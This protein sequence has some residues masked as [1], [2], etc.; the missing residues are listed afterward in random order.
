MKTGVEEMILQNYHQNLKALHINCQKP[1][2]YYIPYSSSITA[3]SGRRES[4]DRLNL[5]SG[6]WYFNYY[7]SSH[8]IPE[9]ILTKN[10]TAADVKLPVPSNWQLHGYDAPQYTN[11]DFPVPYDPPFVPNENPAGVYSREFTIDEKFEAHRHLINF[12][13]VDSCFYLYING[14]FVAYSQVSHST[15]EID[16][17]D[18]VNVGTNRITVI[19]L[20]WC[21]GTYL[22]DQDKFRLS[23]IFRDVYVLARPKGHIEDYFVRTKVSDDFRT[24]EIKIDIKAPS[25]QGVN[26][27]LIDPE[28][29][30]ISRAVTDIVGTAIFEVENPLLWSAET[31]HLYSLI[32]ECCGEFICEKVGIK[33]FKVDN[34]VI[35]LNGRAIKLRGTNRHDSHPDVGYAVTEQQMLKDLMLMKQ[36][37]INAIRSAHYP[38]DP[39]FVQMCDEYGFYL[40]DEADLECHGVVSIDGG[41]KGAQYHLIAEDPEFKEAILDRVQRLVERDKNRPCVIMWSMGNESGYGQCIINAINWTKQRDDTRLVHYEGVRANGTTTSP[42]PDVVSRMYPTPEWCINYL[43]DE[44]ET[45]PLVLCEFSHVLGNSPGDFKEYW[46]IIYSNPR[47]CG[48]FVWEWA[49]HAFELG[50]TKDGKVKYGYGGDF[51]EKVH[52]GLFCLDGMV[53]PDRIPNIGLKEY[54]AVVQPIK[55]EVQNLEDRLFKITNLYDFIYLSRFECVWELTQ[56]G[57]VVEKGSLGAIPIPPQRSEQVRIKFDSPDF[58]NCY[59]RISFKQIENT[60]WA[61]QGEEIAFAQ[62]EIPT[63]KAKNVIKYNSSEILVDEQPRSICLKNENFEYSF[64]KFTG[65][66]DS[67]KLANRELLSEPMQF[68]VWRAP[69]DNDCFVKEQWQLFG[70]DRMETQVR[71]VKITRSG[72]DVLISVNAKMGAVSR[73]CY[74]TINALWKVNSIGIIDLEADV[75]VDDRINYLPRFGLRMAVDKKLSNV[76]YFGYGPNESYVDKHISCHKGRF[77]DTV[78]N[79]LVDNIVPQECG[80]HYQTIWG[81]VYDQQGFGIVFKNDNGFDFSALPHSQEQ[82]Q[83]ATHNFKLASSDKTYLCTDYM[84]SGVGSN[85][86]GPVLAEKFRLEKQFNFKLSIRP[87]LKDDSILKKGTSEY[88][89]K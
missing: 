8:D 60:A 48:A 72:D 29:G 43:E 39:R 21:D 89:C 84:Q 59:L 42:E 15:S 80:N 28:G 27:E 70:L 77:K 63:Q 56:E 85:A 76:E 86:C 71:D 37:N 65:A 32:I 62:F 52:A 22:E 6:D 47:F 75:D 24:A 44:N 41:Y 11:Y 36:H 1:R 68:N 14:L 5:L 64:N 87:L 79:M 57:K 30:T 25:P 67:L 26:I 88:E 53:S 19:V 31:P 2:S 74:V 23:G 83:E 20:K 38:N 49:D 18:Y 82:L 69:I 16:I 33:S 13:G 45:R 50:K 4:S 35:K 51:G 17:T 66:F 40:I 46:D 81:G 58:G 61:D 10:F 54:K 7:E 78:E 55:I 73:R 9:N 3:L 12:E 34:G